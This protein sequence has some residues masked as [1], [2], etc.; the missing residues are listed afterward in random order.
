MIANNETFTVSD[1]M[2]IQGV[3]LTGEADDGSFPRITVLLSK[4]GIS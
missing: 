3:L 1:L 2:V 4:N